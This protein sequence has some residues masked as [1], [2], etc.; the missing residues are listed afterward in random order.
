MWV[1]SFNK[2]L[3]MIYA[4]QIVCMVFINKFKQLLEKWNWVS[5]LELSK[6]NIPLTKLIC[7][8]NDVKYLKENV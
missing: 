7:R 1:Y 5:K 6:C 8:I 4:S 2:Y 3:I